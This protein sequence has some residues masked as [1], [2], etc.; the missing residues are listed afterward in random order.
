MDTIDTLKF[1]GALLFVTGLIMMLAY[2]L[3]RFQ[4]GQR[5][6]NVGNPER[7][8]RVTEVTAIDPRHRLVLIQRDEVEH[9]VLIGQV[10]SMLV[11]SSIAR[12]IPA[13]KPKMK[14]SKTREKT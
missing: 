1:L 6:M 4:I 8:L 7:R 3:R 11:E 2:L 14:K 5:L 9:L 10:H 13:D 12:K